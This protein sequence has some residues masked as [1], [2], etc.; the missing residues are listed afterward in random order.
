MLWVKT[1]TSQRS[2]GLHQKCA[3]PAIQ[4]GITGTTSGTR[5]RFSPSS[6]PTSH[7]TG[8]SQ[9]HFLKSSCLMNSRILSKLQKW[10]SS[11]YLPVLTA[12]S[13]KSMK[14]ICISTY[15]NISFI[16]QHASHTDNSDSVVSQSN[17]II[18][19]KDVM[20]QQV[21]NIRR[22]M[23]TKKSGAR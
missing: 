8:S 14:P 21:K 10:I 11:L 18:M 2:S 19:A 12:W 20:S 4:W 3:Q 9:V 15:F 22:V 23:P 17:I 16:K 7:P 13:S 6:C 1:P 5:S